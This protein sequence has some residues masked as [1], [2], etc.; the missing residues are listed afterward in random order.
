MYKGRLL[1]SLCAM[2]LIVAAPALAQTNSPAGNTAG[3]VMTRGNHMGSAHAEMMQHHRMGRR[4]AVGRRG[5][6]R[7]GDDTSQNAAVDQLNDQSLQAARQGNMQGGGM[8]GG[9]M[10]GGGMA[11]A[12]PAPAAPAGRM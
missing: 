4:T 9:G 2:G 1:A 10:Q 7:R 12:A 11:P 5:S 6:T 8:Q 3:H